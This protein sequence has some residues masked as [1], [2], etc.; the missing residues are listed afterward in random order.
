MDSCKLCTQHRCKTQAGM[1]ACNATHAIPQNCIT[2]P[3]LVGAGEEMVAKAALECCS[4]TCNQQ[5]LSPAV[6]AEPKGL[7][8]N[9]KAAWQC[10][11]CS[12]RAATTGTCALSGRFD[13]TC[14]LSWGAGL[15]KGACRTLHRMH[16]KEACQPVVLPAGITHS[17]AHTHP[18]AFLLPLL[19]LTGIGHQKPMGLHSC[20]TLM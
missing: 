10:C 18:Q 8:Q 19:Q 6:D 9:H 1:H 12:S 3:A 13:S 11:S 5:L 17:W 14:H 2:M 7:K 20:G 16:A 4:T 15:H